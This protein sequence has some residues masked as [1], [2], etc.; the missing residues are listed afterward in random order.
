MRLLGID[1]GLR[2]IGLAISEGQFARPFCVIRLS[3]KSRALRKIAKIVQEQNIKKI[4]IGIS[5]GKMA[6]LSKEFGKMLSKK[7]KI[8]V[9]Y[10]DETLS[11][12]DAQD[13]AIQAHIP[14]R[15]RRR[16]EDAYSAALILQRYLEDC[17]CAK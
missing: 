16:L 5:E 17:T 3:E 14:Q 6:K 1:Y 4:V 10:V 8:E 7:L 13:F 9:N 12:S 15:K 2:K 11:T